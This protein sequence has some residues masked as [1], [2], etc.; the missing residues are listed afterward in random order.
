MIVEKIGGLES[1]KGG[2][3]SALRRRADKGP[4]VVGYT[5]WRDN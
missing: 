1:V 2:T 3:I 5:V 4:A